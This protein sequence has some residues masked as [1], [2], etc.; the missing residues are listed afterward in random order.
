VLT[1]EPLA[2]RGGVLTSEP[3]TAPSKPSDSAK[4]AGEGEVIISEP[5]AGRRWQE[6]SVNL[7]A[8]R[9]NVP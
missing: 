7:R 1:S 8:T 6:R 2:G 3:P 4:G 5:P 9:N